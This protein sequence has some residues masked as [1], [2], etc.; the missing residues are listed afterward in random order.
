MGWQE[1]TSMGT[2]TRRVTLPFRT[3]SHH[4]PGPPCAQSAGG[5]GGCPPSKVPGSRHCCSMC[6]VC[7]LGKCL[8]GPLGG[9]Q[10]LKDHDRAA[11]VAV[12]HSSCPPKRPVSHYT[13]IWAC[14]PLSLPQRCPFP[15]P[16]A[17]QAVT[18]S[19]REGFG[20]EGP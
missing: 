20:G 19:R 16:D 14:G 12:P 6:C 10:V 4:Y 3:P 7:A 17:S 5:K 11:M 13:Y 8:A 9:V 15:V 1:G 2:G 18:G